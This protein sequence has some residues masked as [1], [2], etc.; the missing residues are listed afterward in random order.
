M[1]NQIELLDTITRYAVESKE[2]TVPLEMSAYRTLRDEVYQDGAL[3]HKT[4]RLIALGIALRAGCTACILFQTKMAVEAG[5]SKKEIMET[6]MVAVAMSG[7]TA[8]GWS[9]RVNKLLEEMGM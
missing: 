8:L 2:E 5:A 7:S 4:K 9:W 3:E 1:E 6:V